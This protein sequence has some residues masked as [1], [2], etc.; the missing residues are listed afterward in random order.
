[1]KQFVDIIP[2][3]NK[4]E[5]GKRNFRRILAQ[6]V[7]RLARHILNEVKM[8]IILMKLYAKGGEIMGPYNQLDKIPLAELNDKQLEHLRQAEK[9]LEQEG[10]PV[11]LIAFRREGAQGD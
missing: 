2:F 8:E 3:V 5:Q 7:K 4:S 10:N 1:L 6:A 11:Y 9:L